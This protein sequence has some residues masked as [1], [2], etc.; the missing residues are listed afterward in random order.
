MRI[1]FIS[2]YFPPFHI[3][4]YEELCAEVA[5]G[6]ANRGR[7]ITVLTTHPYQQ[8][9][10]GDQQSFN[11]INIHRVLEPEVPLTPIYASLSF[12]LDYQHRTSKNT[13]ILDN[14]IQTSRPGLI[15]VW[16]G[17]NLPRDLFAKLEADISPP[18]VFY[19]AD[20]W[21][22]L[23]SA[24]QLHWQSPARRKTTYLIKRFLGRIAL[25]KLQTSPNAQKL[26]VKNAICVSEFICRELIN[27]NI[28]NKGKIIHNGIHLNSFPLKPLQQIKLQSPPQLLFTGR[29]VKEKGI[30]TAIKTI[31][32][33][34][35]HGHK[36]ELT[37]IGSIEP[38]YSNRLQELSRQLSIEKQI[39]FHGYIPRKEIPITIREFDILLSP[40]NINEALPRNI[41]E[42][43]ATGLVAIGSKI[44]GIPEIISE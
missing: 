23:P 9:K 16:G 1:L 27:K 43:M 18:T 32:A 42:A 5:V 22:T 25:K 37:L 28:F 26:H 19:F 6:L 24:Y 29:I 33:L 35:Q 7:K 11:K 41:Q 4:G 39:H 8:A 36:T 14:L 34:K 15:F 10:A 40:S 12:F 2:N 30:E 31:A 13:S 3:G 20:L 17:W 21:P 44:G 38:T